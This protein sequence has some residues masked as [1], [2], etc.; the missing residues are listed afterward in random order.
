[1][2]VDNWWIALCLFAI[3]GNLYFITMLIYFAITDM[4]SFNFWHTLFAMLGWSLFVALMNDVNSQF[5][6][7]VTK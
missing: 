4:F 1:M 6:R 7:K 5:T 2:K 3:V